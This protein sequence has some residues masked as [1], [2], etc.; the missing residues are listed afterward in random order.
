[1]TPQ[2]MILAL[3]R[4]GHLSGGREHKIAEPWRPKSEIIPAHLHP[5]PGVMLRLQIYPG[6][7]GNILAEA[8]TPEE[9]EAADAHLRAYG[10]LLLSPPAPAPETP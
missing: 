3:R 8:S 6:G 10:W 9:M 5:R 4:L 7:G 1:M 2:E